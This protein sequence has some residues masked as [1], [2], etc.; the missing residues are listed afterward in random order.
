M[1]DLFNAGINMPKKGSYM[2]LYNKYS[3]FFFPNSYT[4]V[5]EKTHNL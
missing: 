5:M 3:V 4:T 1:A 2:D